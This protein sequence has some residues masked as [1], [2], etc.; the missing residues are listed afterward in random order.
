MAKAKHFAFNLLLTSK[1]EGQEQF[2]FFQPCI[3]LQAQILE[4]QGWPRKNILRLT[5]YL[6]HQN[7]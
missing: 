4:V 2:F 3:E 5:S 7:Y 6:W 1:V